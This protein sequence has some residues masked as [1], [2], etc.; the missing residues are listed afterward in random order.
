[1]PYLILIPRNTVGSSCFPGLFIFF[2]F[3]ENDHQLLQQPQREDAYPDNSSNGTID[4]AQADHVHR[5]TEVY[6]FHP[7]GAG[8]GDDGELQ[9]GV[10]LRRYGRQTR[11]RAGRVDG[12][13]LRASAVQSEEPEG[14]AESRRGRRHFAREIFQEYGRSGTRHKLADY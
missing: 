11:R 10:D 7:E 1:M 2:T 6:L 3:L 9:E 13:C 4:A 12:R 8:R 14:M 5:E